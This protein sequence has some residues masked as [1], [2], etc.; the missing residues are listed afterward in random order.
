MADEQKKNGGKSDAAAVAPP[1]AAT[2]AAA[3]PAKKSGGGRLSAP[4]GWAASAD[5]FLKDAKGF[6]KFAKGNTFKGVVL[7]E[8][9]ASAKDPTNKDNTMK[10]VFVVK[11]APKGDGW[12]PAWCLTLVTRLD[13]KGKKIMVEDE[14]TGELS[15]VQDEVKCKGGETILLQAPAKLLP[16]FML[17][18]KKP[19]VGVQFEVDSRVTLKNNR[20]MWTFLGLYSEIPVDPEIEAQAEMRRKATPSDDGV[21]DGDDATALALQSAYEHPTTATNQKG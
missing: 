13:D 2:A 5:A 14:K 19:E 20:K 18:Y 1:A 10:N 15:A 11:V 8:H 12:D 3:A 4:A 16:Y 6:F 7:A 17:V 9:P 21:G